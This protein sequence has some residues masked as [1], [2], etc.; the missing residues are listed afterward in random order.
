MVLRLKRPS[1]SPSPFSWDSSTTPRHGTSLTEAQVAVLPSP[2]TSWLSARDMKIFGAEPL[3]SDL[4][5]VRCSDCDKPVLRS[6]ISDHATNC[7]DIRSGKKWVKGKSADG[8]VE[9]KKGKKRGV[10]GE[11]ADDPSEPS[12][13]KT[14]I[15]KGRTKG[16]VDY[17]KQC[18][19][20][21]DK[22]LPCSRSLTCKA[23]SMGAKRAVQGR[24]KAYDELLLD[25]NRANNPN[26][27]EPVKKETKAEKKEKREKEK[28]EKKRLALEAAIASGIDPNKAVT[29][30]APKKAQAPSTASRLEGDDVAENLDDLDSEAEVESLVKA[31]QEAQS[32]GIV[33]IPLAVPNSESSWFV[34]RRERLR[35]CRD[36]L[37]SALAPSAARN[38]ITAGVSSIAIS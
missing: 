9:L 35:N 36:L 5:V 15:T 12:K 31:V 1:H 7:S 34:V 6:A 3:N 37:A 13:K 16:P 19:V 38:G 26:W 29:K 10:D 33:G 28:A 30:K 20:I 27:I 23:H 8:E 11:E 25:W 21:N 17:D 4:G 22:G 14:K 18:G 2:P 24:S 32:K